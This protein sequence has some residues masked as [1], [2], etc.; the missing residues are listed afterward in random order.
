MVWLTRDETHAMEAMD[1]DSLHHT[2]KLE[3][4]LLGAADLFFQLG[5][6]QFV[7]VDYKLLEGFE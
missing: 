3:R 2:H 7:S 1:Y 6:E 5:L 4:V